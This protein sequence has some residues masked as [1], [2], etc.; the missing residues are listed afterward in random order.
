M[1]VPG[2]PTLI[3]RAQFRIR[4]PAANRSSHYTMYED[5][6][7]H[8]VYLMIETRTVVVEVW[9]LAIRV[10]PSMNASGSPI[11]NTSKFTYTAQIRSFLSELEK[12]VLYLDT[13]FSSSSLLLKFMAMPIRFFQSASAI[14]MSYK[15]QNHIHLPIYVIH[16]PDRGRTR[17]STLHPDLFSCHI[18]VNLIV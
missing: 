10:A 6:L 5:Q 2:L 18:N 7:H 17:T 4:C 13:I 14:L 3:R 16:F 1:P 15:H 12:T 9:S 8:Y 11:K